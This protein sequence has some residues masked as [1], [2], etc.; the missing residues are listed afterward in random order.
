MAVPVVCLVGPT[1]SGKSG[2][3]LRLAHDLNGEIVN[4]D[5]LQIFRGFDIG[6][7]KPSA[8]ERAAVPHHLIDI[9]DPDE[10]FTAGEF[11]RQAREII[12]TITDRGKLP[13]VAGGTGFY[14]KALI[15]GLVEGPRRDEDLRG[16]LARLEAKKPGGLHRLLACWDPPSALRIHATD[17]QK[18]IRALEF[19]LLER[20]PLSRIYERPR[21]AA[22]GFRVFQVG[23]NPPRQALYP[24][25]D[26]RSEAM[27]RGG[28]LAEVE[29]LLANGLLPNAKPLGAIGYKQALAVLQGRQSPEQALDEMKRDTRRY[30]KRQWTWFRRDPRVFWIDDFGDSPDTHRKVV[31]LLCKRFFWY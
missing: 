13:V 16:R 2:L 1:G 31:R 11:A 23:L 19:V 22:H 24:R 5:S 21:E 10:P 25:L 15:D 12:P 29:Q 26:A 4:C 6:T 18:L 3:A 9:A 30:A 8:E 7:A 17:V 14:L 20:Q 27:W 28:L